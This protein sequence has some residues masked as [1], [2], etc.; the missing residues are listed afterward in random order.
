MWLGRVPPELTKF[1]APFSDG[2]QRTALALRKRILAVMPDAH[3]FVWDATNAVS[4]V[5]APSTRWQ[6]GVVHIATYAKRVNL[7][8][9]DGASLDDPQ[10]VLGGTGSRIRHVSFHTVA[11]VG[12]EWVDD[13][14]AAALAQ[15]G[16]DRGMGDH[17]TTIR[18]S[19][20]PKRRPA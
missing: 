2:I 10:A 5:Y 1:L 8:F 20:G 9:N 18:V 4:L 7:G 17:G 13:Y 11:D 15:A 12:A 16:L 6:D 19:E 3:E 14:L